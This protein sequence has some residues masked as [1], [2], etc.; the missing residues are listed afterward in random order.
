MIFGVM[1]CL[2]ITKL[3]Q[4]KKCGISSLNT[5]TKREKKCKKFFDDG[6]SG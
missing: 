2:M 6:N 4:L 3:E 5:N 1:T